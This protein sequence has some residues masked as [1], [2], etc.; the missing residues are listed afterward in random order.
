MVPPREPKYMLNSLRCVSAPRLPGFIEARVH[1]SY[2][3]RAAEEW[4]DRHFL[5]HPEPAPGSIELN[6]NDY[7]QMSRH[8][9]VIAARARAIE[10]DNDPSIMSSVF[11][12]EGCAQRRFEL[13][14]AD[15]VRSED[16]ILCQSGW[17][18]NVG[19]LQTIAGPD[20]PIY[21]DFFAHMSLHEGAARA[22]APTHLFRHNDMTH[23][24]RCIAQ[25]GPGIIA[26]DSVY[27]TI[28]TLCPV[29]EL[30]AVART[31]GCVL[32]VDESHSLGTH[33]PQGAGVVA[34]HGLESDVLFRTSSL[35]KAF[36]ARGGVIACPA[37][38]VDYFRTESRI[39]IF[40]SAVHAYEARAFSE[41]LRV[42]RRSDAARERLWVNA[43]SLRSGLARLGYPV[44]EGTQQII[45]LEAG[46]EYRTLLLRDLLMEHGVLGAPF[47]PPATPSKRCLLRLTVTSALDDMDV[48]RVIDACAEIRETVELAAW[49]ALRRTRRAP[50]SPSRARN[51]RRAV[52][53]LHRAENVA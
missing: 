47:V 24:E 51:A 16:A 20:V 38:F 53:R 9:S 45:A 19:L 6:T 36:G 10:S 7:L 14:L 43:N 5:R 32:V 42:L 46:T 1:E 17:A 12:S 49:P 40:S 35:S 3:R 41:T 18:A 34:E 44:K 27:S 37:N 26:V 15:H 28:G 21:L 29:R 2:L 22:G 30:A 39:A 31:H 8:P 11:L 13:E 25:N 4:R 52:V 23:L 33:G 50:P 48:R